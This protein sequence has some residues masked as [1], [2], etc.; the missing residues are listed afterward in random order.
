MS[1]PGHVNP[2]FWRQPANRSQEYNYIEYWISLAKTLEKGKFH[3]LFLTDML[4]IYDVYKGPDNIY[5][6]LPGAAQFPITDPFLA[7]AAMTTVTKSL[8]FGI[9]ASTTYEHPSALA[10]RF[11]TLDHLSNGRV[12]WNIV[13]SYLENAARNLGL[14]T[15]IPRDE[16]YAIVM[17][18]LEVMYK[19]WEGSWRDDAVV[20]DLVTRQYTVPER[21][22]RIDHKGKTFSVAGPHTV[23]P[24]CQRTHFIFQAGTSTEGKKFAAK[25]AKTMFVPGMESRIVRKSTNEIRAPAMEQGRDP[26]GIKLLVGML[27]IV[28]ETDDLAQ[29]K[30]EDDLS[31]ADL[32]GSLALFGGWTSAD[33]SKFSDDEDFAFTGPGAI[34]NMIT[35]WSATIPGSKGTEWTKARIAKELALGGPHPKAI[36]SAKTVADILENWTLEGDVD[37]FSL[38]YAVSPVV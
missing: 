28:D 36:G 13:T 3:G 6:V 30:Y 4:G 27:V 14:N 2:G 9:T 29:A 19:L 38:S 7:V 32:E 12:G 1:T 23:E 10:R 15:Q 16:R 21:V 5:S 17:E 24:S 31:Y 20:K 22:R 18:Y 11:S 26:K 35:S 8:S 25:H 33:F 34:Q 37:G